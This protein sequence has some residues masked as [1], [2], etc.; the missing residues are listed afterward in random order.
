MNDPRLYLDEPW[1][2]FRLFVSLNFFMA[3]LS[4]FRINMRQR[5]KIIMTIS[6][7]FYQIA[8]HFYYILLNLELKPIASAVE[9]LP[10]RNSKRK[11][12]KVLIIRSLLM[13]KDFV[14]EKPVS[15]DHLM[16]LMV[17]Q[18]FIQL[19]HCEILKSCKN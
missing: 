6:S 13:E 16:L 14:P 5:F 7:T 19:G 12:N 4:F 9:T 2:E 11:L 17:R 1:L 10:L 8:L 3:F 15:S 18:H